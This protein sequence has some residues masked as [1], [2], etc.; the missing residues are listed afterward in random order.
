[1]YDLSQSQS[2]SWTPPIATESPGVSY[3]YRS[4]YRALRPHA[5][6]RNDHRTQDCDR[7]PRRHVSPTL[8]AL[9]DRTVPTLINDYWQPQR[10][11]TDWWL[12]SNWSENVFPDNTMNAVFDNAHSGSVNADTSIKGV[13]VD[14]GGI[15]VDADYTGTLIF[16]QGVKSALSS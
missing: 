8:E 6:V 9:E 5:A 13:E 10:G 16:T 2:V 1:V 11:S 7:K 4:S 3:D 14:C 12:K 15:E